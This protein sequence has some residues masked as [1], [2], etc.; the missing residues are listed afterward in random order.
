MID[1]T[2][3]NVTIYL[4]DEDVL[5]AA[6]A[7]LRYKLV[8]VWFAP[9]P[10]EHGLTMYQPKDVGPGE[11]EPPDSAAVLLYFLNKQSLDGFIEMLSKCREKMPE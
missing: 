8:R 11:T 4:G 5:M 3:Q 9:L 7:I 1:K 2:N 10:D 6:T